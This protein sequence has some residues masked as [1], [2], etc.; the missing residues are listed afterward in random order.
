MA[1]SELEVVND[2]LKNLRVD[3]K[4]KKYKKMGEIGCTKISGE[5]EKMGKWV[6]GERFM[7][8]GIGDGW[9]IEIVD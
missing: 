5:G 7:G 3:S 4:E 1:A 2:E 9:K 8:R 6:F